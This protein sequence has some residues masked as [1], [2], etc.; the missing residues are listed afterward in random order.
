MQKMPAP[1]RFIPPMECLEVHQIPEG[2]LWRYE[3]KLDGYRTIAIKQDGEIDLFSRNGSSFNSKFPSVLETL[4]TLPVKR[5][6]LDGEIVALDEHGR[7]SF[8][9]LQNIK[10]SKASLRF[11]V[12]DL[13]HIDNDDLTKTI[14]EKRRKRLEKEFPARASNIELS[15]ILVGQARKV[16]AHVKEFEFEGVV[17]KRL[18][19]IYLPAKTSDKWQKQKTQRSDDFLVGGYIPGQFGIEQLVVG[20][21]RDGDFFFVDSVK[22]GFVP[23]TRQK[24]FDAIKG[25]EIQKCPFVNL[26]EK[27]GAHR[28]DWEKMA[29]VRWMRPHIVAEIAFNERTNAGHLRHSKFLRLREGANLRTTPRT[30]QNEVKTRRS[31]YA[32]KPQRIADSPS[33]KELHAPRESAHPLHR[34]KANARGVPNAG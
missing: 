2:E 27:K 3:L 6:I 13:L 8:A 11:Y 20:E 32:P 7:H 34:P 26:P 9:L 22:N 5:F 14:L 28:M 16:L 31:P 23:T 30:K 15:P 4:Q 33:Q 18:D 17:A 19:S 21:K 10:T 24:V 25:K 12:F 1:L 29:T